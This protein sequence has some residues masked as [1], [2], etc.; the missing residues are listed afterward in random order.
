MAASLEPSQ[1][2]VECWQLGRALQGRLGKNVAIVE[3]T[4]DK[5]STRAAVTRG[6]E[7]EKLKN[8]HC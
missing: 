4:V 8:L 3:L 1:L 7:R 2:R 5:S 6:P